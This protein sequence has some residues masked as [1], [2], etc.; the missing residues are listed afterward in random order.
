MCN[1]ELTQT[2]N[3]KQIIA[4]CAKTNKERCVKKNKEERNRKKMKKMRK[5]FASTNVKMVCGA[6]SRKEKKKEMEKVEKKRKIE[7]NVCKLSLHLFDVYTQLS[8]FVT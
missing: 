2:T 7:S 1:T 4:Q 6:W 5:K 3:D 8:R